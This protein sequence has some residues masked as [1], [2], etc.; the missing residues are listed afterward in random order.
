MKSSIKALTL[1]LVLTLPFASGIAHAKTVTQ[2]V[3]T[4]VQSK[5]VITHI[6]TQDGLNFLLYQP[7]PKYATIPLW[8][9]QMI[10]D[11]KY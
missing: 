7:N 9:T 8:H 11:N 5:S 3:K 6:R 10:L 2:P 4:A 1:A